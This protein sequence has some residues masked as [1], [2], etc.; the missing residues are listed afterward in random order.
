MHAS[1]TCTPLAY[2]KPVETLLVGPC[3]AVVVVNVG[4]GQH[5][6]H[7][8]QDS[9]TKEGYCRTTVATTLAFPG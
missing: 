6:R 4:Q 8:W 1:K 9:T 2:C 7:V 3:A 5:H